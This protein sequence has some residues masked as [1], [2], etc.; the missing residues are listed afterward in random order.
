MK[1]KKVHANVNFYP[2]II[3]FDSVFFCNNLYFSYNSARLSVD[4]ND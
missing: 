3:N 4:D 2:F 1:E